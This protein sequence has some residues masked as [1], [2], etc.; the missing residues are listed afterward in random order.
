MDTKKE[1]RR[2]DTEPT[3]W[4][5]PLFAHMAEE[6]NLFLT[7]GELGTIMDVCMH[8]QKHEAECAQ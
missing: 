1:E 2:G 7:E 4:L 3:S 8:I 6:H 5:S